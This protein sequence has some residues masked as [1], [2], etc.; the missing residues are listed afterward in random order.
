MIAETQA[1]WVGDVLRFWFSPLRGAAVGTAFSG[2]GRV[3]V[4]GSAVVRSR[5]G[6]GSAGAWL[7]R[8]GTDRVDLGG[9]PLEPVALELAVGDPQ[10]L[11]VSGRPVSTVRP[12][13]VQGAFSRVRL[14]L[15][16]RWVPT[17]QRV[18]L[19][20]EAQPATEP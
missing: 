18:R 19:V 3:A 1:P 11:Q 14:G 6:A 5:A 12:T 13:R 20:A 4:R 7:V 8:C 15:E 17:S 16:E 9:A 2:V 10:D